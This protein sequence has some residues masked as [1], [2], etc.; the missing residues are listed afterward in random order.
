MFGRKLLLGGAVAVAIAIPLA[1]GPAGC[2]SKGGTR[3]AEESNGR[4]P[5]FETASIK[6]ND[7]TACCAF[8]TLAKDRFVEIEPA[9]NM[10]MFAYGEQRPLKPAQ[11]LGGPDW[12]KTQVFNIDAELPRSLWDQVKSLHGA[13]PGPFP[14]YLEGGQTD[15]LKQ[16]FRSLLIKAGAGIVMESIDGGLG[17]TTQ[18]YSY[19]RA[20]IGSTRV[21]R[22]AGM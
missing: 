14:V 11:V 8:Y 18:V 7:D 19:L 9:I 16:I 3:G 20:T 15:A 1:L 12:T 6:L 2:A 10:I 21:A 13:G 4:H 17:E 5:W 22:R